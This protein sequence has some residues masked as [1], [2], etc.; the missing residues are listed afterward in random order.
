MQTK[1]ILIWWK[2]QYLAISLFLTLSP[3]SFVKCDFLSS[4]YSSCHPQGL[5]K[6]YNNTNPE[7]C[8]LLPPTPMHLAMD[9]KGQH[10]AAVSTCRNEERGQVSRGLQ[11]VLSTG[12]CFLMELKWPAGPPKPRVPL[13]ELKFSMKEHSAQ[14]KLSNG[15]ERAT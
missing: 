1:E 10:F 7:R 13:L 11:L 2:L 14:L 6:S 9:Q 5:K 15:E 3:S 8:L 12:R 4:S